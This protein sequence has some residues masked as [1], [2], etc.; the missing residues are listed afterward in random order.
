MSCSAGSALGELQ[1][2]SWVAPSQGLRCW[3][4][5]LNLQPGLQIYLHL[6]YFSLIATAKRMEVN[7]KVIRTIMGGSSLSQRHRLFL[8]SPPKR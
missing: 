3:K 4:Q 6:M 7:K 2:P 1:H 8:Y 5:T